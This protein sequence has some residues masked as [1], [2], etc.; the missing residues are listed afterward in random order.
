M[1]DHC[2]ILGEFSDQYFL[3]SPDALAQERIHFAQLAGK[4]SRVVFRWILEVVEQA[5]DGVANV[6][7]VREFLRTGAVRITVNQSKEAI[8]RE[9]PQTLYRAT[10]KSLHP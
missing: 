3:S 6:G 2:T 9:P 10:T 5:V 7:T 1:A 8:F 4:I